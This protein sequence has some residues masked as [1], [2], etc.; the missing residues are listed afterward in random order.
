[1]VEKEAEDDLDTFFIIC[2]G[3][4]PGDVRSTE[5]SSN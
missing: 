1:M 5:K 3:R 2:E 4:S